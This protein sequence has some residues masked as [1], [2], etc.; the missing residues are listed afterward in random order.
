M[1]ANASNAAST[2]VYVLKCADGKFYVGKTKNHRLR[3]D[4]HLTGNGA[5]WTVMYP[6]IKVVHLEHNADPFDEDKFVKMYM[7]TYGIDNVRGGSYSQIKLDPRIKEALQKELLT[8][9]DK[10]FRCKKLGHF[11]RDCPDAHA[12]KVKKHLPVFPL[13]CRICNEVCKNKTQFQEHDC[14][15][16]DDSDTDTGSDT[17]SDT[18]SNTESDFENCVSVEETSD[19]FAAKHFVG[20]FNSKW[21]DDID[22]DD[23]VNEIDETDSEDESILELVKKQEKVKVYLPENVHMTDSET[24]GDDDVERICVRCGRNSHVVSQCFAKT[25]LN[26]RVL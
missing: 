8:A 11:V 2:T 23:Q 17:E 15:Y 26:G 21:D 16:I 9:G 22:E 6:P 7:R 18:E 12:P 24:I 19:N 1:S 25:H 20:C 14:N 10:C 3:I 4:Q 5:A 13:M